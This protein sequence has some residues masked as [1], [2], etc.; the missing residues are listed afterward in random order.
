LRIHSLPAFTIAVDAE[1]GA[2]QD[3]LDRH[4]SI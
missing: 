4:D 1:T 3:F 2:V